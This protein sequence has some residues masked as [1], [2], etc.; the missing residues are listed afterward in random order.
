PNDHVNYAIPWLT[1]SFGEST[2]VVPSPSADVSRIRGGQHTA[3]AE[4]AQRAFPLQFGDCRRR[5]EAADAFAELADRC[6]GRRVGKYAEAEGELG[7]RHVVPSLQLEAE[8]DR[9]QIILGELPMRR[10]SSR[11][12]R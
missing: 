7:R 11:Q 5:G 6:R 1:W 10:A 9:R 2:P 8:L 3:A 4:P 12:L